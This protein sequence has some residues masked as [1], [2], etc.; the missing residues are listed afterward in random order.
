MRLCKYF[1]VLLASL[2]ATSFAKAD[3]INFT[4]TITQQQNLHNIPV[5]TVF[6]GFAHYDGSI[7]PNF[8]GVPPTLTSYGFDFPSAPDSLS[9]FKWIFAQRHANGQPLFIDLMYVDY[10]HPGASFDINGNIFE[11]ILPYSETAELG[12][13][14]HR[15]NRDRCLQLYGGPTLLCPGTCFSL[16][17]RHWPDDRFQPPPRDKETHLERAAAHTPN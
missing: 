8:T 2:S 4:V 17:R 12:R 13:L 5:G 7:D 9:D 15:G 11:T 16:P 1:L 3:T 10:S 6:T 14:Y